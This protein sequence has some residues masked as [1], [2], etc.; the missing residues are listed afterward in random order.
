MK[1]EVANFSV[2][3]RICLKILQIICFLVYA[4]FPL[5]FISAF[6]NMIQSLKKKVFMNKMYYFMKHSFP[7]GYL[8]L[9][10]KRE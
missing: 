9:G 8:F 1:F 3:N 5:F 4:I 10:G 2:I 6:I 7:R